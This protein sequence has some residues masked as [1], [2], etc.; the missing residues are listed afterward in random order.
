MRNTLAAVHKMRGKVVIETMH[1]LLGSDGIG[2]QGRDIAKSLPS[3][4]RSP[5]LAAGG[6][7][8][9]K[10]PPRACC[11]PFLR[12]GAP[13]ELSVGAAR[14]RV[15]NGDV[16]RNFP[17]VVADT[18]SMNVCGCLAG[19]TGGGPMSAPHEG[20]FSIRLPSAYL[21]DE[22]YDV[23][24]RRGRICQHGDLFRAERTKRERDRGL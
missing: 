14:L 24:C 8:P 22:R 19:Q 23:K 21:N 7:R 15:H 1:V 12:K 16:D 11:C 2:N 17:L 3:W 13:L 20:H 9:L 18:M 5:Y 4:S 6:A 10:L